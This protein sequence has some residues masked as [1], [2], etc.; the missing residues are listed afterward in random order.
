VAIG[1]DEDEA[2]LI[3]AAQAG[4]RAA[5]ER[6]LLS[7]Q[8]EVHAFGRRLCPSPEDAE[9]VLQETLFA[10]SRAILDFRGGSKLSTWLYTIAR[11]NCLRRM[12]R[13]RPSTP[14]DAIAKT[15]PDPRPPPDQLLAAAE[16]DAA[17]Q[18]LDPKHREV[19]VLRD[20]E[21][22]T[23]PEV[24]E[25]LGLKVEAVKSRLHRA[26]A[27]LRDALAPAL[28]RPQQT[29]PGPQPCPDITLSFSRYLEGDL[30]P[31]L[32]KNLESHLAGCPR[33]SGR[34]DT[35][36]RVLALCR[37]SPAPELPR[38]VQDSVQKA[39]RDFLNG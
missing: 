8:R 9:D 38:E 14:L 31:G 6:L 5:L 25:I 23:A 17:I 2:A 36:K 16:I 37:T 30:D 13:S 15:Y 39:L 35:L 19:L 7:H 3:R 10:A 22:L 34:C 33:C 18:G 24:G 4:D 21:G 11:R 1:R 20:I 26:R 32:C 27:A 28:D 29:A 12:K